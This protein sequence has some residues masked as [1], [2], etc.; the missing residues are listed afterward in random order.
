MLKISMKASG[1]A[2]EKWLQKVEN[3]KFEELKIK[4]IIK[5]LKFHHLRLFHFLKVI[6]AHH[7]NMITICATNFYIR[8]NSRDF[9]TICLLP[10]DLIVQACGFFIST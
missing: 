8:S 9:P 6:T 10:V 1:E 3:G 7:D 2:L 4:R 5:S